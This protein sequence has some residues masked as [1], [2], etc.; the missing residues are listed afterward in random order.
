MT[1]SVTKTDPQQK[2]R[3]DYSFKTVSSNHWVIRGG[4]TICLKKPSAAW[5]EPRGRLVVLIALE[6]VFSIFFHCTNSTSLKVEMWIRRANI[7]SSVLRFTG[8]F[9]RACC[10]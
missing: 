7:G 8:V 4:R 10:G 5:A 2:L 3:R 1:T 9:K 6:S